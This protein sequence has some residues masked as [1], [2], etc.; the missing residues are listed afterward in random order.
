MDERTFRR[1]EFSFGTVFEI[2]VGLL[3]GVS[4][5]AESLPAKMPQMWWHAGCL[6][7]RKNL[8]EK[9]SFQ[10]LRFVALLKVTT[11]CCWRILWTHVCCRSLPIRL[12]WQKP[13]EDAKES[14]TRM[15]NVW[16]WVCWGIM[17]TSRL[18]H[19][20]TAFSNAM[21][22]TTLIRSLPVNRTWP[23]FRFLNYR[24]GSS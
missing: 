1:I 22:Q 6:R 10:N 23:P 12:I 20:T 14:Q 3:L 24:T 21:V 11:R 16:K 2:S 13:S 18:L 4:N 7:M 17:R 19:Y 8:P 15:L 5:F 9:S